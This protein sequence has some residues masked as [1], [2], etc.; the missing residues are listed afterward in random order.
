MAGSRA[1]RAAAIAIALVLA[2]CSGDPQPVRP[3]ADVLIALNAPL[4]DGGIVAAQMA[5]GA[6]LAVDQINAQGGV[7]IAGRRHRITL[8][9]MD[10]RGSAE[11]A[12]DNVRQAIGRGAVAIVDEGT[13]V[14]A[15]SQDAQRAGVAIGV[16][17]HGRAALIDAASRPNVFRLAPSNAAIAER[18]AAYVGAKNLKPAIVHDT[19]AEA[20]DG[21]AALANAFAAARAAVAGSIALAPTS[22]GADEIAAARA[23]GAGAMVVWAGVAGTATVIRAARSAGWT[24]PIYTAGS[25]QD[26]ALRG[27][28]KDRPAWIDGVVFAAAAA[29]SDGSDAAFKGFRAAYEKRFGADRTG[30]RQ[31]G[32]D[33]VQPPVW[34]MPSY[35]FV[36]IVADALARSGAAG[37]GTKLLAALRGANHRGATGAPRRF[38]PGDHEAV[39]AS[40]IVFA[41]F[42]DFVWRSV[43]DD[44]A[45]SALPD[46]D[47]LAG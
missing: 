26:P 29:A 9:T 23:A 28:L 21:A 46:I 24:A 7:T 13:G 44:P 17:L 33:V 37:G 30:V 32:I 1:R 36:R 41:R 45:S 10:S 5:N 20:A 39:E 38:E 11:T 4:R 25:G 27:V 8:T 14:E 47:Q 43:K 18:I 40:E 22:D 31:G 42:H 12:A 34:A 35:D 19:S 2:S 16:V 3:G 15:S 6:Q